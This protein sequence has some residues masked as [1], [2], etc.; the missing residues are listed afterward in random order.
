MIDD[1]LEVEDR[2]TLQLEL[3]PMA[4]PRP[5]VAGKFAYMPT[6]YLQW[7]STAVTFIRQQYKDSQIIGPVYIDISA[8]FH[9]PKSL[10][11]KKDPRKRILKTTKPDIDNVVKAVLDALQDAKVLKDDSQVVGIMAFKLYGAMK[12]DKKTER[13]NIKIDIYPIKGE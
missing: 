1:T 13:G 12:D 5:R 7:K 9:R 4:C 2:I 10:M 8:I 3:E 11:R 6:K